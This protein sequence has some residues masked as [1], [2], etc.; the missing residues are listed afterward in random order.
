VR[1]LGGGLG[2]LLRLE[3]VVQ[4]RLDGRNRLEQVDEVRPAFEGGAM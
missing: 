2:D 4:G 3:P 1:A